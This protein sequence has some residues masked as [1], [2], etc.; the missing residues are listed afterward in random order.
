YEGLQSALQLPISDY[1]EADSFIDF[2]LFAPRCCGEQGPEDYA[3]RPE[4]YATGRHEADPAAA[5]C[6]VPVS[7]E[8]CGQDTGNGR[9]QRCRIQGR[10]AYPRGEP[11]IGMVK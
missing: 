3:K 11:G 4:C 2:G 6:L 9:P 8:R 5:G 10:H 1:D 7:W